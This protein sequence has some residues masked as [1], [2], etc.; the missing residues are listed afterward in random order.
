MNMVVQEV[1]ERRGEPCRRDAVVVG[2]EYRIRCVVA[3]ERARAGARTRRDGRGCRRPRTRGRH[4]SP[5]PHRRSGPRPGRRARARGRRRS[6][7]AAGSRPRSRRGSGRA[8]RVS[9]SPARSLSDAA[10]PQSRWVTATLTTAVA[11][12]ALVYLAQIATPAAGE[13]RL[14]RV[15][16]AGRAIHRRRRLPRRRLVPAGAP[17]PHRRARR[18]RR[19]PP[20]WGSS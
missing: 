1:A 8:W 14:D 11:G 17:G 10:S 9:S 19:G 4:P 5:V 16:P 7:P 3:R 12:V 15:S 13:L 18:R 2:A 20:V 6:R